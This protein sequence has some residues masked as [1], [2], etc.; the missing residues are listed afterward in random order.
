LRKEGLSVQ[1]VSQRWWQVLL[2][3][4]GLLVA[5]GYCRADQASAAAE[6]GAVRWPTAPILTVNRQ[7]ELCRKVL[8]IAIDQFASRSPDLD[9]AKALGDNFEPSQMQAID[10][11]SPEGS[12]SSLTFFEADLDGN[13][14]K[15]VIVYR[16]NT[17]N[18]RGDWHYAYVFGSVAAFTA[19]R[20]SILAKWS[21]VPEDAQYPPA[22]TRELDAQQYYPTAL[23]TDGETVQT[24]NVWA[25]HSLFAFGK[26]QYFANGT[27]AFDRNQPVE[28]RIFRLRQGGRVA[29]TCV[30]APGDVEKA[31]AALGELPAMAALLRSLRLIGTGGADSGTLHSGEQH[32]T[33]TLSAETRAAYRPWATSAETDPA[34]PGAQVYFRYDERVRQF[35]DGWSL[36][37]LWNRREY[38]TMI[39]LTGPA[40]ESYAEYLRSA[41]GLKPDA[42]R[43]AAIQV[44]Q[45][46]IGAYLLVPNEYKAQNTPLYF[47]DDTPLRVAV[48]KR[49]RVVFEATLAD[50]ESRFR[51]GG[52]DGQDARRL[53]SEVLPDAVEWPYALDRLL[54]AGAD[55]NQA[56]GFGKSTL[57]VAAHFDRPD[58]LD[59][60]IKAGAHVNDATPPAADGG[61][62]RSA[63]SRTGRTALMYAA[64]NAGPASLRILLEAGADTQIRDSAGNGLSFYLANN[65]RFTDT[66]RSL[67][68]TG[69]ARI[70]DQFSGPSFSCSI[71]Q[72]ATEKAICDSGM[73][74]MLDA[75]I[76]RAFLDVKR[77][78]GASAVEEQR[79]W[80]RSRDEICTAD[81]DCLAEIMRTHL[82]SLNAR[83]SR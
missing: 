36:Q 41:F 54:A 74:R 50:L 16:D 22:G 12:P 77:K 9:I 29:L 11:D 10:P 72:T 46:L 82:R 64:E 31:H 30:V 18:W 13:G 49:D 56:N 23:T 59:K 43:G 75:Q 40:E 55:P 28:T 63:P 24:G 66:E 44:V 47:P 58:A 57:M 37:E 61:G 67:G 83:L 71:T 52:S 19:A 60:L 69:L 2:P 45:S 8:A 78:A 39:E 68:V 7:S 5:G 33:D 79:G 62:W 53:L 6:F 65:P 26:G 15:Q 20:G 38:Q 76:A 27:T 70:A 35:L 81:V 21:S 34:Y 4:F 3:L 51:G 32:D 25:D 17:F 14:A 73:L 42:A 48:M 80:L 1:S